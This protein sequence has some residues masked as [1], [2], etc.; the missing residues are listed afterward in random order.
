MKRELKQRA[1]FGACLFF[2]LG[3][4]VIVTGHTGREVT[5]SLDKARKAGIIFIITSVILTVIALS[6]RFEEK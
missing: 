1:A 6:G 3:I 5:Q 4:L 2:F